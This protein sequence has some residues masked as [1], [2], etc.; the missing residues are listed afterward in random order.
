MEMDIKTVLIVIAQKMQYVR[1]MVA[2]DDDLAQ[3]I[4]PTKSMTTK[5]EE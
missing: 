5:T 3:K 1:E 4:V 2:E